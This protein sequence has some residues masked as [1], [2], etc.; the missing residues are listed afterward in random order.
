MLL[1]QTC[2][3]VT[4]RITAETDRLTITNIQPEDEGLYACIASENG[5]PEGTVTAGC[6]IVHG[7]SS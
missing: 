4:Y 6:I 2:V 1:L 7:E 5:A 3:T